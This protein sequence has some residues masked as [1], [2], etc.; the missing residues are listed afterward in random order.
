VSENNP[1]RRAKKRPRPAVV[2]QSTGRDR[3]DLIVAYLLSLLDERRPRGQ[4]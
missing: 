2:V 4:G 1:R 3:S